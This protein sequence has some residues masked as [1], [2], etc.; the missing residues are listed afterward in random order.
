MNLTTY[1][2]QQNIQD[3]LSRENS[4]SRNGALAQFYLSYDNREWDWVY[5]VPMSY[6]ENM[7]LRYTLVKV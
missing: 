6:T 5:F 4:S 7:W 3:H 1:F 2:L